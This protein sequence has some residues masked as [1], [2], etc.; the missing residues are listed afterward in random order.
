MRIEAHEQRLKE[1][2]D[3]IEESIEAGITK[4]QRNIGFNA[5]AAAIDMLEILLHKAGKLGTDAIIKHEWLNSK[6]KTEEKLGFDFPH[7]AMILK[8]IQAIESSRNR[9]CYGTPRP[10]REI[11]EVIHAFN[12]LRE[13]FGKAEQ[14]TG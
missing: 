2:I 9:L 12:K 14:E 4:R 8:L 13:E 5:S 10:E 1:S 11:A 6:R 3:V 7:K